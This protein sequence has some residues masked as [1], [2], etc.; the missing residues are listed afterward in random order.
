LIPV[1]NTFEI[2]FPHL[3]HLINVTEYPFYNCIRYRK[4]KT[5]QGI[6]SKQQVAYNDA[7][8]VANAQIKYSY[9]VLPMQKQKHN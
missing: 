5:R 1:I 7:N 4:A 2:T 8:C 9:L 3:K 6:C